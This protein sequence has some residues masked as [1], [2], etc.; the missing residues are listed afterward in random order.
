MAILL[1]L[2]KY[3]Y[4]NAIF[5][6]FNTNMPLCRPILNVQLELR[7]C[8]MKFYLKGLISTNSMLFFSALG[9]NEH[10]FKCRH[11]CKEYNVEICRIY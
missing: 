2:V 6:L 1:N 4:Q 10:W 7:I 5:F 8:L 11:E 3:P 9:H